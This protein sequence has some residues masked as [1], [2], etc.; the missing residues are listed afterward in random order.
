MNTT[1][2]YTEFIIYVKDSIQALAGEGYSVQQN[3][4]YKNNDIELDALCVYS[5]TS[6][7]SPSI[8]LNGYYKD[9][10]KGRELNDI[11]N[12]IYQLFTSQSERISFNVKAF[13]DYAIM[14][15]RLAYKLINRRANRRL[16]LSIPHIEYLDL[17]IVFYF[18]IDDDYLGNATALIHNIHLT[19]WDVTAEELYQQAMLNTPKILPYTIRHINDIVKELLTK[20]IESTVYENDYRYDENCKLPSPE[21]VAEGVM[22]NL[23]KQED[24]VEM[25]VLTN[26]QKLFGASCILYENVLDTFA[27]SL[28][29][30]LYIIPS[31]IHEV[32]LVPAYPDIQKE[33]L[34]KM[35]QE[36]NQQ[37]LNI[38]DILSD[39]YY[40]YDYNTK[41]LSI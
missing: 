7:F 32:I 37:E 33:S 1:M 26:Q 13:Q 20:D 14:K 28:N 36:V 35:I 6:N 38:E 17:A 34:N 12:E 19:M 9:Y 3:K 23:I 4:I 15:D 2:E 30:N 24:V 41:K 22:D 39:H 27:S 40:F 29:K 16:L 8:Y 18:L 11:V 5:K 10:I 21:L 31:S 25:Y